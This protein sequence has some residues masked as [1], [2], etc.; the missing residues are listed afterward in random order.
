MLKALGKSIKKYRLDRGLTQEDLSDRAGIHY[1]FLGHIERGTKLPSLPTLDKI[2]RALK[3]CPCLLL[4]KHNC[5][6]CERT[7]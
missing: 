3:V 4:D 6:R 7:S 1:T 5:C 2:A